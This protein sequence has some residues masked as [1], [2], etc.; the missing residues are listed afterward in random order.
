MIFGAEASQDL[1]DDAMTRI[2]G[3]ISQCLNQS[4]DILI[5]ARNWK[6]HNE[7]LG[8][9]FQRAEDYGSTFIKPKC[10]FDPDP[11]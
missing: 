4:D 8:S 7:T 10:P 6:E 11:D 9:V 2:F 5:G 1:F 3:D